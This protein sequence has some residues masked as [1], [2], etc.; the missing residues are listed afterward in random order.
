VNQDCSHLDHLASCLDDHYQAEKS[1]QYNFI[2]LEN[3]NCVH[4][5]YQ[6]IVCKIKIKIK[7]GDKR[8]M[9]MVIKSSNL[10]Q[11]FSIA[12]TYICIFF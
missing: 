12:V 5:L 4:Y 2:I 10:L 1:K 7:F 6:Y 8:N 3:T 9:M 11:N